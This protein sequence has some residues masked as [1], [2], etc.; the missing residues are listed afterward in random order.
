MAVFLLLGVCAWAI[1]RALTKRARLSEM[2]LTL[3]AICAAASVLEFDHE[4]YLSGQAVLVTILFLAV[5]IILRFRGA[6]EGRWLGLSALLATGLLFYFGFGS[7]VLQGWRDDVPDVNAPIWNGRN[8]V[9]QGGDK[10]LLNDQSLT[11]WAG[12]TPA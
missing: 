5:L 7:N 6:D 12:I 10:L 1:I 3:L 2:A 9:V 4:V 8:Y 11:C